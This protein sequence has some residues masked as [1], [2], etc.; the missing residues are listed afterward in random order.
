MAAI[1]LFLLAACAQAAAETAA[2]KEGSQPGFLLSYPYRVEAT[3][4]KIVAESERESIAL[5]RITHVFVGPQSLVGRTFEVKSYK[6]TPAFFRRIIYPALELEEVAIWTVY[7]TNGDLEAGPDP[8]RKSTDRYELWLEVAQAQ[9]RVAKITVEEEQ[10]DVLKRYAAEGPPV[11]SWAIKTLARA[12]PTHPGLRDFLRGLVGDQRLSVRAQ[13]VLDEVL[14]DVAAPEWAHSPDRF[15]LFKSWLGAKPARPDVEFALSRLDE[16]IQR[17]ERGTFSPDQYVELIRLA[18]LNEGLPAESRARV[19]NPLVHLAE[20]FS[21]DGQAFDLA[22][23]ILKETKTPQVQRAAAF[24]IWRMPMDV[25]R[26]QALRAV[27]DAVQDESARKVLDELLSPSKPPEP[28]KSPWTDPKKLSRPLNQWRGA[29]AD[30]PS[31]PHSIG[32]GGDGL[33]W[34][35]SSCPGRQ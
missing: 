16:V 34:A 10:I 22:L 28:P 17:P 2:V 14:L 1:A 33:P 18:A 9:E 19:Q 24:A 15:D 4:A 35:F 11:S 30:E 6:M 26:R 32:A 5:V 20:R 8:A 29:H 3:V 21:A 23:D 25:E 27:Q 7:D 31:Q 12:V 13:V